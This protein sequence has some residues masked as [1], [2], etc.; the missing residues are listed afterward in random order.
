MNV[1]IGRSASPFSVEVAEDLHTAVEVLP[2]EGFSSLDGGSLDNFIARVQQYI[3]EEEVRHRK[4]FCG[5]L[6]TPTVPKWAEATL[7]QKLASDDQLAVCR[8]ILL[9]A[10]IARDREDFLVIGGE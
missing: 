4:A 3:V 8:L 5:E 6:R 10:Q 7:V 1:S 9:L 2:S